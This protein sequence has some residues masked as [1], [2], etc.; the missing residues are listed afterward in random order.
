MPLKCLRCGAD[1]SWIDGNKRSDESEKDAAIASLRADLA[2][3]AAEIR[4]WREQF[5]D[6]E[7]R[8]EIAGRS[9][10][11]A[12]MS[13]PHT[14]IAATNASPTLAALIKERQHG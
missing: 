8:D 2:T 7:K 4:A 9:Y 12:S 6:Y 3:A 1:S 14:E 13:E 11:N 10:L 5:A